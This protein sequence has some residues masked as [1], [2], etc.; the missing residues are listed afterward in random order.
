[1]PVELPGECISQELLFN[2]DG[3]C[4]NLLDGVWVRAAMEVSEEQ[5]SETG[6]HGFV[7][8]DELVAEGQFRHET[9]LLDPEDRREGAG[10]EDAFDGGKSNETLG[11]GRAP[12]RDPSES[13]VS[14]LLD[15][16]NGLDGIKEMLALSRVPDVS[17][18]EQ[19]IG[20]RV[21]ILPKLG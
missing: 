2:G 5:A 13:P 8:A 16:R 11:E 18:D 3:I 7:T 4:D 19:R 9:T 17:V 6:V 1:M 21:D 10:E 12:V 20:L 14:L 15:A